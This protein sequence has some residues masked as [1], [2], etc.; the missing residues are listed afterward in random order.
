MALQNRGQDGN[1]FQAQT[2]R[3]QV[4]QTTDVTAGKASRTEISIKETGRSVNIPN[5][6]YARTNF[7][8]DQSRQYF[9]NIRLRKYVSFG[10]MNTFFCIFLVFHLG[11]LLFLLC[12]IQFFGIPVAVITLIIDIIPLVVYS[13]HVSVNKNTIPWLLKLP[14][15]PMQKALNE[16]YEVEI[17]T[18][19]TA[20]VEAKEAGIGVFVT[21]GGKAK[22]KIMAFNNVGITSIKIASDRGRLFFCIFASIIAIFW[23]FGWLIVHIVHTSYGCFFNP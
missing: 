12:G 1:V 23:S 16:H 21:V 11:M 4:Y 2:T 22:M 6:S 19:N 7:Y 3:A 20:F 5:E 14:V 10:R 15:E 9:P 13:Q 17:A 8:I 18:M